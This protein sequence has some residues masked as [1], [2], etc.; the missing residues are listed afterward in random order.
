[1]GRFGQTLAAKKT[2]YEPMIASPEER[3]LYET[4]TRE[5]GNFETVRQSILELSRAGQK[6]QAYELYE[7][8]GIVPAPCGLCGPR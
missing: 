7:Q 8:K 6:T 1:M 4:F 5:A 2:T 3:T